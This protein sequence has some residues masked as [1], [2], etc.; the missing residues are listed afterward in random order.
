VR[1]SVVI[2]TAGDRPRLLD[3]AVRSADGADEVIVVE[4][5]AS[6]WGM[7]SRDEGIARATGDW[8]LF[9][10]DDDAFAPGVL[11]RIRPLLDQGTWHIF[12]M[13]DGVGHV[14]RVREIMLGNVG[15]PML[16]VPNR[17][18]LPR[19]ADHAEYYGDFHFAKGCQELLGEPC[20][21]TETLALIRPKERLLSRL[22]RKVT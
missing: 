4:N 10:D 1:L 2:P 3:R 11:H 7:S 12:R 14:W 21:H 18:D 6:P 13:T 15:T 9:M 19:W 22:R 16:V 5:D 17:T 20:W 8:I